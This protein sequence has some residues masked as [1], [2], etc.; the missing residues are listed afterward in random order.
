MT[1]VNFG[2]ETGDSIKAKAFQEDGSYRESDITLTETPAGKGLYIGAS[3]S[4]LMPG[5]NVLI[6]DNTTS[7]VYGHGE[8]DDRVERVLSDLVLTD[9]VVDNIYSDTAVIVSDTA[10]VGAAVANV[11]SDTTIIVSDGIVIDAVA[12]NIY[13]DTAVLDTVVDTIASDLIVADTVIDNIYSDTTILVSDT[14]VAATVIGDIYSDTTILV[15]DL[16]IV[17]AIVDA[18]L[19]NVRTTEHEFN[20]DE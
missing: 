5:D 2:W 19:E 16:I 4:D 14:A 12:D 6:Y 11:Y 15:S 9:A 17:D 18:I 3:T 20:L 13:S 8:Y 1:R 10:V 7:D